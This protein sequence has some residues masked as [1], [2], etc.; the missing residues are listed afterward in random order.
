MQLRPSVSQTPPVDFAAELYVH[1]EDITTLSPS[2]R[3]RYPVKHLGRDRDDFNWHRSVPK[4]AGC[5]IRLGN[6]RRRSQRYRRRI[7][8]RFLHPAGVADID[9]AR[10]LGLILFVVYRR[11]RC[12]TS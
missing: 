5:P 1:F 4:A 10:S 11:N 8:D 2:G 7:L 9:K 3:G 12:E 6:S